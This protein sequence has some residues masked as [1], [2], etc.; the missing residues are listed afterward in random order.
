[1]AGAFG[2]SAGDFIT[3]IQLAKDVVYALSDTRGARPCFQSLA[4]ELNTLRCAL[5]EINCIGNDVDESVSAS[6]RA[7]RSELGNAVEQCQQVIETFLTRNKKFHK[8]LGNE[9]CTSRLRANWHKIEWAVGRKSE[10]DGLRAQILGHTTTINTLLI[11]MQSSNVV[12][13]TALL[14]DCRRNTEEQL[15]TLY[16]TQDQVKQANDM[17]RTQAGTLSKILNILNDSPTDPDQQPTESVVPSQG[18]IRS[19]ML[20]TLQAN[21]RI[22]RLM[23][24]MQKAVQQQQQQE[25]LDEKL[26]PQIR[27]QQPVHF[28]DAHGRIAPFHIEF[29]NSLDAFLAVM[30][31][32]FRHL[33]GLSKVQ[34]LEYVIREPETKRTLDLRAPWASVFLP[35]R[36]V[37]MSMVFWRPLVSANGCP[38]C[39]YDNKI[40][41]LDDEVQCSNPQCRI[42]YDRV[43]EHGQSKNLSSCTELEFSCCKIG[44]QPPPAYW[45]TEEEQDSINQF[46]RVQVR[47]LLTPSNMH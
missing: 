6:T 12:L 11:S 28:E 20:Q 22:C 8:S 19:V 13:Q 3:G 2:F 42:W 33:P 27:T 41:G 32:R 44:C 24:E 39:C 46:K 31:V 21:L 7:A 17:I 40:L 23:A 10:V 9:R 25:N 37:T 38:S 45:V 14:S 29:V 35:G 1:M 43:V 5:R 16:E 36:R 26:P 30:E 18:M 4:S 34:R 47:H 15:C